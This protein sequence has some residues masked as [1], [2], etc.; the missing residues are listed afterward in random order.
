MGRDCGPVLIVDDDAGTRN[1]ISTLLRRAGFET[2]E[3]EDGRPAR[4][5]YVVRSGSV[6]LV[7]EDE[8][9]DVLEPGEAFGHPSLL[10]GM[11]PAFDVRAREP[12]VCLL[13]EAA[14]ARRLLG[15]PAGVE[16]V[17]SSLRERLVRTGHVAHAQADQRT[18]H[19]GALVD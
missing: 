19:L 1:L 6:E 12:T 17:A 3:A 5:L 13:I 8:Q 10:S 11:A 14:A 18:A 9:I 7:H 4:H 15:S 16:Y 2:R